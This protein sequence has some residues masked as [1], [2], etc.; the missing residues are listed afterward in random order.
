M[1]RKGETMQEKIEGIVFMVLMAALFY[2]GSF[3]AF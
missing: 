1:T 2:F 3:L